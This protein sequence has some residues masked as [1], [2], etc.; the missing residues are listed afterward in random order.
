M[1]SLSDNKTIVP[2]VPQELTDDTI[3]QLKEK[4]G[5]NYTLHVVE[6]ANC[7]QQFVVRS[8]NWTE[9]SKLQAFM[10]GN[11]QTAVTRAPVMYISQFVVFPDI[12]AMELE[13]NTSGFWQPGLIL[14]LFVK[15]QEALGL[16]EGGSIKKL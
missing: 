4:W 7:D 10:A 1:E 16:K 6:I 11:Q 13:T 2:F 3:A 12:N 15:I 14:S 9:F 8:S 5:K